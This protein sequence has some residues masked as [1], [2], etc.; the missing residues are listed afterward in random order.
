MELDHDG[1]DH[2]SLKKWIS[3]EI[4]KWKQISTST[5]ADKVKVLLDSAN[6]AQRGDKMTP[7][8]FH[9]PKSCNM[10]CVTFIETLTFIVTNRNPI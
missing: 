2:G 8:Y 4:E 1:C 7:N 6:N 10:L 5:F 3:I 9:V